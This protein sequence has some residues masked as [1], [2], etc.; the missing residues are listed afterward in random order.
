MEVKRSCLN[1]I[2]GKQFMFVFDSFHSFVRSLADGNGDPKQYLWFDNFWW[3]LN[4]KP[5][6]N[7]VIK[8]NYVNVSMTNIWFRVWMRASSSMMAQWNINEMSFWF[9]NTFL[10]LTTDNSSSNMH[11]F[12]P[13][14]HSLNPW[15]ANRNDCRN[16]ISPL[17]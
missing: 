17:S 2:A 5:N 15:R 16:D 13:N 11:F 10:A 7:Y 12:F 9:E 6:M 4:I 8:F 1:S 3:T 14:C